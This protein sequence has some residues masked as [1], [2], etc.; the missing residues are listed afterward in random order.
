MS[1]DLDYRA[2]GRP[3]GAVLACQIV[4]RVRKGHRLAQPGQPMLAINCVQP[5]GLRGGNK[6]AL[7]PFRW[8]RCG[9]PVQGI[10]VGIGK[11][12]RVARM[13]PWVLGAHQG[14]VLVVDQP[15]LDVCFRPAE[16]HLRL[17]FGA[18]LADQA[19]VNCGK[20]EV[21]LC[22]LSGELGQG[23]R[24]VQHRARVLGRNAAEHDGRLKCLLERV[25]AA[26]VSRSKLSD[27]VPASGIRLVAPRLPCVAQ[28]NVDNGGR[29]DAE[30]SSVHTQAV[31]QDVLHAH[32]QGGQ[33]GG[34]PGKRGRPPD[35]GQVRVLRVNA[36][37][38]EGKQ[39]HG[40][41]KSIVSHISK[42]QRHCPLLANCTA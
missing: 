22:E 36:L 10:A 30:G 33:S 3:K 17:V 38:G 35:H 31:A 37:T 34:T 4:D 26:G 41:T 6:S 18:C 15:S 12:S 9:E 29:N 27:A 40:G 2:G 24:G 20:R 28:A 32:P 8:H 7:T 1:A 16:C 5:R 14:R 21:G 39:G 42:D 23:G 11:R 25:D 19:A 13:V